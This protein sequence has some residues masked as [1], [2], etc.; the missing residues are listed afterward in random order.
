MLVISTPENSGSF[1]FQQLPDDPGET[2]YQQAGKYG[3][4]YHT[5]H[6]PTLQFGL[7]DQGEDQAGAENI[8]NNL[9]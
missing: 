6:H 7:D 9:R 8:E 4:E 2:T 5:P 1:Q 3:I